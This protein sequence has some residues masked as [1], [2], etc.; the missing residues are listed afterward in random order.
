MSDTNESVFVEL[1]GLTPDDIPW[2]SVY[3][4]R[5]VDAGIDLANDIHQLIQ[6]DYP[7]NVTGVSVCLDKDIHKKLNEAN[8][9][10]N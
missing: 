9:G 8:G 5:E 4:G 6:E 2:G 3:D 1:H 7:F 10:D